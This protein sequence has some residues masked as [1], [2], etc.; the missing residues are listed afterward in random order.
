MILLSLDGI[1]RGGDGLH[2]L[3]LDLLRRRA[4]LDGQGSV[5]DIAAW[6]RDGMVQAGPHPAGAPGAPLP[7]DVVPFHRPMREIRR[8]T[9]RRAATKI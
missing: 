4:A 1:A 2:P 6:R 8:D 5:E 3:L 7:A 9:A